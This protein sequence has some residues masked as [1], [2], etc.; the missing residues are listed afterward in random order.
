MVIEK[1]LFPAPNPPHYTLTSHEDHL[2]WVPA[3]NNPIKTPKLPCMF[4]SPNQTAKYFMIF[5]HGNGCD[6][7]SMHDLLGE[8]SRRIDSHILAFEY[9]SY[10]LCKGP[11]QPDR[12]TI[13][14]NAERA[15]TF[16]HETLQ[17]PADR[18]LM[19]GHSIGSGTACHIASTKPVGGLILQSPYTSINSLIQEKIGFVGYLVGTSYW[20]NLNTMKNIHCPTLF[21]HGEQDNLIP[22][23]HSQTLHDSL[24]HIQEKQLVLV[25]NADHNSIPNRTIMDNLQRFLRNFF[26][27]PIQQ[28]PSI[29]IQ[30][31][32]R[33]PP[34]EEKQSSTTS[35][36]NIL[37][38]LFALSRASTNATRSVFE[39]TFS[40]PSDTK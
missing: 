3:G 15:Y 24:T 14:Q 21:I 9:P 33:V 11:I 10:G 22:S 20:N 35:I 8:L 40:K 34:T 37:S 31:D 1:I 26:P 2:L 6:I 32:L 19:Y 28:L 27:Q 25:S 38:P 30:P 29:N 4:Y 13:D 16:V 39:S 17:W 23:K 7:G 12:Y 36:S 5:C 18:I